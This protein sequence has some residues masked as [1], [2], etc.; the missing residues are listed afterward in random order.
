MKRVVFRPQAVRDLEKLED[1][2]RR[3]VEEAIARFAETGVGDVKMLAG[4][5]RH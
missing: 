2:D 3:L 1:K 4:A 5:D